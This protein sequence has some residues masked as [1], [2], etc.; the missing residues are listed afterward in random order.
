M[1]RYYLNETLRWDTI[2]NT[3]ALK[4]RGK[5]EEEEEGDDP[6]QR[7]VKAEWRLFEKL[8]DRCKHV[9]VL[10][11]LWGEEEA[12]CCLS[13]LLSVPSDHNKMVYGG[14]AILEFLARAGDLEGVKYVF[15]VAPEA[16]RACLGY[17][18]SYPDSYLSPLV[19]AANFVHIPIARFLLDNGALPPP[20]GDETQYLPFISEGG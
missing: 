11:A 15:Q 12:A 14:A 16:A 10:L 4:G 13:S 6:L 19:C 7:R 18:D 5:E 17:F 2:L 8:T 20:Q 9:R 3:S 1:A